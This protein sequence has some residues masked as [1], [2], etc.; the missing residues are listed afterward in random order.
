MKT[1][2][3]EIK[4]PSGI[5]EILDLPQPHPGRMNQKGHFSKIYTSTKSAGKGEVLKITVKT[6]SYITSNL[7][8]LVREYNNLHNEGGE[9][10]IP[11][12][13]YFKNS[14]KLAKI[15]IEE[16]IEVFTE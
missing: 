3:I 11:D 14:G 8:K 4:R 12:I 9:G 5:I 10:Y 6:P 15:V 1:A 13:E 16:K 7:D 2:T